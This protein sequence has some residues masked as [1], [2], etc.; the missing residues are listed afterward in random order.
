METNWINIKQVNIY[1]QYTVLLN[2]CT[3][4]VWLGFEGINIELSC[5]LLYS[6]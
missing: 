4:E 2:R 6:E 1:V 5:E 3:H